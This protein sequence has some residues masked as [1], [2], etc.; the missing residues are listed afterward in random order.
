M[1]TPTAAECVTIRARYAEADE[2]LH[3]LIAGAA[4]VRVTF[5]AGKEVEYHRADMDELT[6][7]V[8]YLRDRVAQCDG[9][10]RN[11]RAMIGTI[12]TN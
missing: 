8:A 12:P 7:Y 9:T 10:T 6:R 4:E 2:A 5:G 11:N 3:R 1:A